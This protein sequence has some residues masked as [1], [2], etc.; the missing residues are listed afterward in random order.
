MDLKKI[1]PLTLE[2]LESAVPKLF[3]ALPKSAF[4]ENASNN[5]PSLKQLLKTRKEKIVSGFWAAA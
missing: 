5:N 2:W 3:W 1:Q 4:G